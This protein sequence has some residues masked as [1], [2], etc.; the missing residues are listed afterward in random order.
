MALFDLRCQSCEKE[1][2]KMVPFAKLKEVKCPSCKSMQHER[3]YKAN[4][5]GPVRSSNSST[6]PSLPRFS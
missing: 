3:V 6:Q 4:V 5:T 1:F 2:Q